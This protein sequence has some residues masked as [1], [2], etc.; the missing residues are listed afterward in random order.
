MSPPR[1]AFFGP[2]LACSLLLQLGACTTVVREPAAPPR[3]VYREMPPPVAEVRPAPPL[4]GYSWVPGHYVWRA[5]DW[6]W[7]PGFYVQAAV[8]LVPP[9]IAEQVVPAPSFRHVYVRGHWQW[10]GSDWVWVRGTW[11]EPWR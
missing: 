8:R 7:Q 6:R 9:L 11:I 3:V 2:A 5:N 1:A 4:P 10:G